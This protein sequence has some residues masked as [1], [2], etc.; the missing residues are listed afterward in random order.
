MAWK[1][2]FLVA[3]IM[4]ISG[5]CFFAWEER[6]YRTTPAANAAQIDSVSVPNLYPGGEPPAT[7]PHPNARTHEEVSGYDVSEGKRLYA[8]MNC[9]GCHNNGGGGI[10]PALMD[11]EW[12][13][14]SAPQNIFASIVEGRPN[15]MP[16]FRGKIPDAQVWQI[17]AYVRSMSGHV[18]ISAETTRRDAMSAKKPDTLEPKQESHPHGAPAANQG[19]GK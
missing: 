16:S 19:P 11:D 13:Y 4:I 18:P 14:G 8:W 1:S 9:S 7:L 3:L 2:L 5:A 15:G 10:G 17:V 6:A 12:I